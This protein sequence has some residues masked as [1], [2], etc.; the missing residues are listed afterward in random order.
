MT[1]DAARAL[2]ERGLRVTPQRRAILGAF[3]PAEHLSADEVH[4]RASAAVPGVSRGTVYA[5][6]SELCEHGLV[7]AFGSSEPVR[8]ETNTAP[9]QHF[10][11]RQCGR[12]FDVGPPA[13]PALPGYAVE[14]VVV[15]AHGVCAE[16]RD[17]ERGA[18]DGAADLRAAARVDASVLAGRGVATPFGPLAVVASA[19]GVV[20]IA[21]ADQADYP[22]LAA[23]RRRGGAAARR[24]AEAA[25]RALGAYLAGE[26]GPAGGTVDWELV[27]DRPALEAVAAIPWGERRSYEQ[28]GV[29]VGAYA[30]GRAFGAN[31]LPI[32]FPC[33]RV[34]CGSRVPD[35]YVG[36][37][38]VRAWLS[39]F[40]GLRDAAG[41]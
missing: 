1:A 31:P 15:T 11:C 20:R 26:R 16:C 10:R 39:E 14:R 21:F 40:E 27:A 25:A 23:R 17:F 12:V 33:H 35:A 2:R 13:A 32:L 36:G 29:S 28:L 7:A 19:A 6:L 8:Y 5:T 18:R 37:P 3:G 4:A 30:L 24:Q 38:A 22:A 41:S 34:T 9:H